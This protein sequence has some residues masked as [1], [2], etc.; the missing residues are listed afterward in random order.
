VATPPPSPQ[1]V[2]A[3]PP[4]HEN[5]M[6]EDDGPAS[7]PRYGALTGNPLVLLCEPDPVLVQALTARFKAEELRVVSVTDGN[8][9]RAA[10]ERETPAAIIAEAAL[11][12]VDGFNLLL[13]VRARDAT[14]E[15]PFFILSARY[16]EKQ[17]AKAL[18]LGADDFL[19]KPLNTELLVGKLKRALVK[20]QAMERSRLDALES[21]QHA[22]AA[23]ASAAA[24]QAAPPSRAEPTGVIGSLVQMGLP[25][26]VQS[27]ELGRKTAV[28][29]LMFDRGEGT[30]SFLEGEVVNAAYA[31]M[32]GEDAFYEMT[33]L[34]QGLFRI[35]Y[36]PPADPTR[37]IN[38]STT[39]LLLEAM[40]RMDEEGVKGG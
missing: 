30:V 15:V 22:Q 3:G 25:E 38:V 20:Y 32:T 19:P 13:G 40:R 1:L 28:V 5:T 34:K 4:I 10:I 31:G 36:G 11:P 27:L 18:D 6:P 16:D 8:Q 17:T 23:Q 29:T 37:V 33:R 21:R 14:R 26:I 12:K 2:S 24:S 9:A 39:F 7:M 35:H